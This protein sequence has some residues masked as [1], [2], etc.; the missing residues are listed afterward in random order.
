[1]AE[2][3]GDAAHEPLRAVGI[4]GLLEVFALVE[5]HERRNA[6]AAE[7]AVV[8]DR[9]L[10]IEGRVIGVLQ[11]TLRNAVNRVFVER[12]GAEIE[13]RPRISRSRLIGVPVDLELGIDLLGLLRHARIIGAERRL[14]TDRQ[15]LGD[16]I[17]ILFQNNVG[18]EFVP[19][20][21]L[22]IGGAERRIGILP[23]DGAL[24]IREPGPRGPGIVRVG[25]LVQHPPREIGRIHHRRSRVERVEQS[26]DALI[27]GILL[28]AQRSAH[29]DGQRRGLRRLE[30]EIRTV[31]DTIV[32]KG[33]ILVLVQLLDD[34]AFVHVAQRHEILHA[35]GAAR[36]VEIGVDR[37]GALLHQQ[38]EPVVIRVAQRIDPRR[39]AAVLLQFPVGIKAPV[40]G[41]FLGDIEE[42]RRRI[43]GDVLRQIARNIESV[44]D[45]EVHLRTPR[46]A[47]LGR[48]DDHAVGALGAEHRR[49]RSVLQNRDRLDLVRVQ[50]R[51]ITLHAVHE[52][53]RRRTVPARNAA[54]QQRGIVLARLAA[55]L[56]ARHA[57]QL[58][59]QGIGDIRRARIDQRFVIDLRDGAH[60]ALLALNAVAHDHNV[61]DLRCG[62]GQDDT[63]RQGTLPDGNLFRI[64]P[65]E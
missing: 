27:V 42:L 57:R 10:P 6:V 8:V 37:R 48:H 23:E 36:H 22:K 62:I 40:A 3:V 41:V 50:I 2:I 34:G 13:P 32:G 30:I 65:Q 53:Q 20:R 29:L 35:I 60:D 56:D 18:E 17:E 11:I 39:G 4:V 15:A 51:E 28:D 26:T 44:F 19:R 43:G 21:L 1:M 49:G 9:P 5:Q 12:I 64:V 55:R 31:V 16:E 54:D 63:K 52:D 25:N 33:R 61:V 24:G 14:G 38:V 47:H 59:R 7:F 45:G 58:A 46:L